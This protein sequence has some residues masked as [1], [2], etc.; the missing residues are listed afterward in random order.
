MR[1]LC[2]WVYVILFMFYVFV[3]IYKL[4]IVLKFY[5][6]YQALSLGYLCIWFVSVLYGSIKKPILKSKH[7]HSYYYYRFYT[8]AHLPTS[9]L[10]CMGWTLN[11][12]YPI[13]A[14][15]FMFAFF[16]FNTVLIKMSVFREIYSSISPHLLYITY[17]HRF[18]NIFSLFLCFFFLVFLKP[19]PL[20]QNAPLQVSSSMF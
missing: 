19:V 17:I 6:L 4:S 18:Y 15:T 12:F 2:V 20:A 14:F 11:N 3:F 9:S 16:F 7:V 13:V 5:V 8:Y 1:V 10:F